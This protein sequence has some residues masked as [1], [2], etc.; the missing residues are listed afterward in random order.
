MARRIGWKSTKSIEISTT[1][2]QGWFGV[3]EEAEQGRTRVRVAKRDVTRFQG[4]QGE[5]LNQL[6]LPPVK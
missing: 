5:G 6:K 3:I 4:I 1:L 2:A